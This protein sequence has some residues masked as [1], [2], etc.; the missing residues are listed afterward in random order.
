MSSCVAARLDDP[1]G[2]S[3]TGRP[4]RA[5]VLG[6]PSGSAVPAR[7][8][9]EP[10]V[11]RGPVNPGTGGVIA[12]DEGVAVQ[13]VV[14][15]LLAFNMRESCGKCSPCRE[16][17]ARLLRML[18][19]PIERERVSSLAE[20]IQIASL[21]GLGQAAPLAVLSALA[22]FPGEFGLS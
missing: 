16:G 17:T 1:G 5:P 9:D 13:D 20:V 14:R 11:P 15:T 3:A 19:G 22:E 6:G 21:C 7:Q 18:D 4:I 2:G 8:F 10:L 12:L